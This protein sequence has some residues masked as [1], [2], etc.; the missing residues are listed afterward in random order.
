MFIHLLSKNA[1][2]D[3]SERLCAINL[4]YQI[5]NLFNPELSVVEDKFCFECKKFPCDR[6]KHLD[7]RYRTKYHMR[8]I[9][10]LEILKKLGLKQFI[11]N[12]QL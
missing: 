3:N 1:A 5:D 4:L 9:E 10:N 12:E 8:M 11:Q 6:L 2:P 7:K